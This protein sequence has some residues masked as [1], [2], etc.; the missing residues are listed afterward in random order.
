VIDSGVVE[1]TRQRFTF[2]D[3]LELETYAEVKHEFLDG[4]VWAMAGGT[5]GH[6]ALCGRMTILLGSLLRERPCE[7]FN[8]D[9]RVRVVATG[10]GT[11]PDVTV[12]CGRFEADPED[13]KGNTATNPL[14]IVEVLSPSTEQYDRGEKLTHYRRIASLREVVL[15]AQDAR[16]VEVW[17]RSESGGWSECVSTG[18]ST[19]HLPSLGCDLPLAEIYRDPLGI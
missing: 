7:V 4:H 18:E 8:S 11:Y 6:A 14:V 17:S 16:R 1:P 12:I 3:Y 13:P 5:R 19:A 10:L 15:V 9:L 2:E